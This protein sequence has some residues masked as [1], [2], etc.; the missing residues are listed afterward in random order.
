[1]IRKIITLLLVLFIVSC[2]NNKTKKVYKNGKL[3]CT[4]MKIENTKDTLATFYDEMGNVKFWGIYARENG[5]HF[6][7]EAYYFSKSGYL[8][9]AKYF[10]D[11]K[12]ENAR[13]L[14][15]DS[16]K[17]LDVTKY[18][19]NKIVRNLPFINNDVV[20]KHPNKDIV[21]KNVLVLL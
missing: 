17:I 5:K 20:L 21:I 1:M 16:G 9:S 13:V 3:W 4:Y 18:D 12:I 7:G 11:G 15:A 14:F 2:V 8:Q 6:S 10:M 19:N